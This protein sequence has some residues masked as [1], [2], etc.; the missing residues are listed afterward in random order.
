MDAKRLADFRAK[1]SQLRLLINEKSAGALIL[2]RQCNFSWLTGG[3]GFVGIASTAAC[4]SLLI[5]QDSVFLIAENME[6]GRLWKE[7]TLENPDIQICDYP[8]QQPEN[9]THHIL[10]LANGHRILTEKEVEPEL[11]VLRT[12]MSPY[13]IDR[14]RQL[15]RTTSL[16][17][18]AACRTLYPGMDEYELS[19]ELAQ[20]FIACGL[21]PITILIGFDERAAQYRHPVPTGAYLHNHALIA[22][23]T[24][25]NGLIVSA[26]RMVC[27]RRDDELVRRQKAAGYVDAVLCGG[28]RPGMDTA[29]LFV[30]AQAAYAFQGFAEEWRQHHQGGLTGYMPRE[31]KARETLHHI[32]REGEVYAWNPSVQGTKSEN[33]ILVT[34]TGF[35]NLTYTGNWK[36]IEHQLPGGRILTEDIL[37]LEEE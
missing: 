2:N 5:R 27:L 18:E 19:S 16:E 1:L 33:T 17:L 35:E 14:Y 21:E 31:L 8:W 12:V 7:Q 25:Q 29:N 15:A 34:P 6:A 32:I 23:C 37:I 11:F 22:V 4:G 24:R 28:T 3:R 30:Q 13:D 9:R 20:R 36:Y 10:K 26:T